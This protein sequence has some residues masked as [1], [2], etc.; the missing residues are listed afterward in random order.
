[1][2]KRRG[3]RASSLLFFAWNRSTETALSALCGLLSHKKSAARGFAPSA[4]INNVSP[5][6]PEID[7]CP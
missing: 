3:F 1:M 5:D 4:A 2:K 6:H 7:F